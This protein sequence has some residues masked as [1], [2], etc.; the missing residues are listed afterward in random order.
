MKAC[1]EALARGAID[2]ARQ[3]AEAL[4]RQHGAGEH[5]PEAAPVLL[6]LAWCDVAQS[7]H[8]RAHAR[9]AQVVRAAA[10]QGLVPQ[11][12]VDGLAL[13]ARMG[14][15]LGH[16]VE[17]VENGL[18]ATRLADGLAPGPWTVRAYAMLGLAHGWARSFAPAEEA[19]DSAARLVEQHPDA[20][21][22]L[23]VAVVRAWVQ[24]IR[25]FDEGRPAE[26]SQVPA[27]LEA[28]ADAPPPL[29]GSLTP[30]AAATLAT[31][32]LLVRGLLLVWSGRIDEAR[33]TLAQCVAAEERSMG[34]ML[35]AQSWLAAE[36]AL[37]TQSLEVAAMHAAR[38]AALSAEVEHLP[39]QGLGHELAAEVYQRQGEWALAL[40]ERRQQLQCERTMRAH[41]LQG[42][43]DIAALRLQARH[44]DARIKALADQSMTFERWAHEDALTGIANL[45]RFN[46]CLAEWSQAAE[47]AGSPLCVALIDVDNFRDINNGFSYEVGNQALRGIA[48][49]MT[50]HVR[51]ADLAARWGGDEFAILFRDTDLDTARQIALRLQEAVARRDWT[52]VAEGLHVGISVGVTEAHAGDTKASLVARSEGLMF[53]QKQARKRAEA[54]R[55]VAP[56]VLRTV[57]GWLRRAQ[58]VVM[59]VGQGSE[60]H[61]AFGDLAL[62]QSDPVA[63][64]RGWAAWRR[65]MRGCKPTAAHVALVELAHALPQVTLVSERVDGLLVMAGAHNELALYGNAFRPRCMGCG[66][67]N[68]SPDVDH[69][70]TCGSPVAEVRP[71]IVLRGEPVDA[72]LHGAAKLAMKRADLILVLDSDGA[73]RPTRVMVDAATARGAKVVVLGSERHAW[74]AI[75]D[76]SIAAQPEVVLSVLLQNLR[77]PPAEVAADVPVEHLLSDDGFAVFCYLTGQRADANGF[78]IEQALQWKDWELATHLRTL[79]WMFP[80][81]TRSSIDP[82]AP[83]P[84]RHDGR[85]LAA[86]PP[87]RAGMAAALALML[88]F[89]GFE[90]RD[91]QVLPAPG[92]RQGFATWALGA[93]HHD[94]FIS[95]ILGALSLVGMQAEARQ[96][97]AAFETAVKHYRGPDADGPLR[98]WRRAAYAD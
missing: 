54:E 22:R 40:A 8:R 87:V 65:Q 53:E 9:A 96:V 45:R 90:Q 74:G 43:A 86:Q 26:R 37:A 63:F 24:A 81:T 78:T 5:A 98:H 29:S 44:G 62:L 46:Q 72:P 11:L 80:L 7:R 71:D 13:L 35:A 42:R 55:A 89:Y 30:G 59:L 38:M 82:G 41:D 79:P 39:L 31:S 51:A 6:R 73:I 17:A 88:R 20:A 97:L 56:L 27:A 4:L 1:D 15:V 75:A 12:E 70:T 52:P 91:G 19:F 50:A 49:E 92:W 10:G 94:L 61:A 16:A 77:E 67:V 32:G 83:V 48:A 28:L 33:R 60:P 64:R 95:R 34:W 58:R 25:C 69:C 66:K 47:A 2:E 23:E 76:V 36:L 3:L 57:T 84:S 93:T 18:L 68:P 14:S 85:V 21:M